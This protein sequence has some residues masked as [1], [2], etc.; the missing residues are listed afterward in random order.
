[1]GLRFEVEGAG[2]IWLSKITTHA[3]ADATYRLFENGLVLANPSDAPYEFD[4]RQTAPGVRYRRLRGS[5][6]QDPVTNN[7]QLVGDTVTLAACDS[8]FLVRIKPG[9]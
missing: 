9:E 4:L 3:H 6:Q 5:S 8:L 2:P 7:G 1:M